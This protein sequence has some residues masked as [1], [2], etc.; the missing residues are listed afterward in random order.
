VALVAAEGLTKIYAEVKALDKVDIIIEEG[1]AVA[2]LGQNGA[3]KSTLANIIVGLIAPE[4]PPDSGRC[5]VFGRD[6]V[7][8]DPLTRERIALISDEAGPVSWVSANETARLYASLY[9][10]W[11]GEGC[12]RLLAHWEIDSARPLRKLSKGQRRLAEIALAASCRPHLMVLDE[13][14]NGLDPVMRVRIQRLLS[15]LNREEGTTIVYATHV[16]GEVTTIANR[17]VILRQGR[18]VCDSPVSELAGGVEATFMRCYGLCVD[19][20]PAAEVGD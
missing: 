14:F 19:E 9:R 13:P 17:A 20:V 1:E 7:S 8:L 2:L 11:D 5:L 6:S 18:K 15:S 3:G 10:R 4:A 16:L 12:A